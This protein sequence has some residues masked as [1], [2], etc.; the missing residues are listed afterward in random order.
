VA[1][2]AKFNCRYCM[3]YDTNRNIYTC[4]GLKAPISK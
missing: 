2:A 3:G 4:R 1:P